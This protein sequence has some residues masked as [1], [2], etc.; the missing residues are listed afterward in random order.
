MLPFYLK[1]NQ[2]M[3]DLLD[4]IVLKIKNRYGGRLNCEDQC[5]DL[6]VY[7]DGE[8]A[9]ITE[10]SCEYI[11]FENTKVK[12]IDSDIHHLAYLNEVI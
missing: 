9:P 10:V 12:L 6:Y 8:E 5:A 1:P 3:P 4:E 11:H 7:V 2:E